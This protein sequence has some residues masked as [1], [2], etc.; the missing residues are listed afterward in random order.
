[1]KKTV[2]LLIAL[3]FAE[4]TTAQ[5]INK[6][7]IGNWSGYVVEFHDDQ[8]SLFEIE[9]AIQSDQA[10]VSYVIPGNKCFG[11]LTLSEQNKGSLIFDETIISGV[12][13]NDGRIE[14]NLTGENSI[15]YFWSSKTNSGELSYG[16]LRRLK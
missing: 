13:L 14:L 6:K 2:I 4:L 11:T 16:E 5:K 7:F 3:A 10:I 15:T 1:M 8:P 9:I 12:C